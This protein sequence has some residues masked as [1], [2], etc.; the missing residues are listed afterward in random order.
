MKFVSTPQQG[1]IVWLDVVRFVAIFMVVACHCTDPF[2]VAGGALKNADYIFWGNV[3]GSLLRP[4]VPLFVMIT[5]LLLLPVPQDMGSF[6]KKRIPRVVVP[7]L[8]W[9]V[10]YNLF[11]WIV[12]SLGG[13][14]EL[15][16]RFFAYASEPSA[17]FASALHDIAMIP[18]NFS[19]YATH[20]W[21]IYMLVGLYLYMPVFSAW[22]KQASNKAKICVLVLW[23]VT[24]LLPYAERFV[25]SNLWGTCSWNQF[26]MLYYFAGFNG[27]LLLGHYLKNGTG[28]SALKTCLI[29]VPMFA[30]GYMI[31]FYGFGEMRAL[32]DAT[33]MDIELFFTYCSLNVVLMTTALFLLV[34][35]VKVSSQTLC[36]ILANLTKCGLG[37]YMV[38]YFYVGVGFSLVTALQ[39][40]AG[41]IV[42]LSAVIAFVLAWGTVVLIYRL[43]WAK[44]IVG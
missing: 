15:V 32:P 17:S 2:N 10:L 16:S 38:H 11:P 39:I 21:Y 36:R 8:I 7:F 31:T 6:Y 44:W 20:L 28:W 18:F 3:Y 19:V 13:T 34:Q 30:V 41:W 26:G 9:S 24:L 12:Q 27:Y 1:H 29:A 5:G 22:V 25:S 14:P 33:E 35:R 23:G 40:P 37:I 42:P 4:C 43:P